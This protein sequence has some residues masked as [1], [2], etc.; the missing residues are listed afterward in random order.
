MSTVVASMTRTVSAVTTPDLDG[1][2]VD[3]LPRSFVDSDKVVT[4]VFLLDC[5]GTTVASADPTLVGKELRVPP[6]LAARHQGPGEYLV[7]VDQR[8]HAEGTDRVL[9]AD[10]ARRFAAAGEALLAMLEDP[11]CVLAGA[12]AA[13]H[14]GWPVP[15]EIWPVDLYVPEPHLVELV[16]THD[17][18]LAEDGQRDLVLRAIPEVLRISSAGSSGRVPS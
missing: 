17:L 4:G 6:V 7:A 11:R 13:R 12:S 3:E 9:G 10:S 16:E 1:A 15:S 8:R 14:L 18:D 5:I 2:S